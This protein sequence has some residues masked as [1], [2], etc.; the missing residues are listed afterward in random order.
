MSH[1]VTLSKYTDTIPNEDSCIANENLIAISDGA[2][3][4]GVFASDWSKYLVDKIPIDKPITSFEEFDNWI[5][6]IW[7]SFYNKHEEI[8]KEYDGIFQ[9]KFYT[10]GSCATIAAVWRVCPNR[11]YY[12]AYGD[13]VVFHYSKTSGKLEHSFTKLADFSN[14]PHL[15]SCKDPLQ[16][17]GF[18]K[19]NF[20]LEDDSVVF[21]ASDAVSHFVLMMYMVSHLDNYEK[22]INKIINSKSSDATMSSLALKFARQNEKSFDVQINEILNW[23]ENQEEFQKKIID[24]N[25]KGLIDI[26]DYT[27]VKFD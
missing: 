19:G 20:V 12:I 16:E 14:P 2:G 27:I 22:D 5:D 4:C 13:S 24:L 3:G 25:K 15:I 10:E 23:C 18:K 21:A 9:K 6:S 8:A 11:C 17:E 1:K 7:E 26:D